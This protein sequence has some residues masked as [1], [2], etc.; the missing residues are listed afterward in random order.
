MVQFFTHVTDDVGEGPLSFERLHSWSVRNPGRFWSLCWDFVG[1]IG[2]K[3]T[4]VNDSMNEMMN[5]KFFPTGFVN[6][7]ENCLRGTGKE[8]L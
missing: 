3:G 1:V 8:P 7:A 6:F 2:E 5:A 4:T